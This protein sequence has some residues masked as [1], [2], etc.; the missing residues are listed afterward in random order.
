MFAYRALFLILSKL[1]VLLIIYLLRSSEDF[2]THLTYI[3]VVEL[4]I[5]VFI[6]FSIDIVSPWLRRLHT[7]WEREGRLVVL[8]E[9]E[10]STEYA[11]VGMQ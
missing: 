11:E 1:F 7:R 8:R 6:L 5:N 10:D 2:M 4:F 3:T 9:E